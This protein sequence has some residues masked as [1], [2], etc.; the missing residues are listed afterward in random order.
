MDCLRVSRGKL[1]DAVGGLSNKPIHANLVLD[2]RL[3]EE[4]LQN[5]ARAGF[6]RVEGRLEL[7]GSAGISTGRCQTKP[8]RGQGARGSTPS[9]SL[10][11]F[12]KYASNTSGI[13]Y[14]PSPMSN[15]N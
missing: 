9:A 2:L 10:P 13:Q 14:Q 8:C 11:N 5:A 1:H 6:D 7:T 15:V 3:V 12:L 4:I